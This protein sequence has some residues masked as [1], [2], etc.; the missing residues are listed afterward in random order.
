MIALVYSDGCISQSE[1]KNECQAQQWIPL[2]V[3]RDLHNNVWVLGFSDP[4]VAKQFARR[5]FPKNWIKG[6]IMLCDEDLQFIGKNNWKI[7]IL[8]FPRLL[9][10]H[11]EYKLGF[12]IL[13]FHN[14]PD[15]I[16]TK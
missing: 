6:S 3:K 15:L 11:P 7:E 8:S 2:A 12:E 10:S 5:N 14:K 1:L 13:E 4:N 16:Y 9:N